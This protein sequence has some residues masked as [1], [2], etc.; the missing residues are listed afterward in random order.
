MSISHQ[1]RC[2]RMSVCLVPSAI[3]CKL[4]NEGSRGAELLRQMLFQIG[5]T[6]TETFQMLQQAYGEE[7]LSRTQY[8]EWYQRTKSDRISSEDDP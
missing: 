6:F 1:A 4:K 7:C 8:Y 2:A 3:F 5:K